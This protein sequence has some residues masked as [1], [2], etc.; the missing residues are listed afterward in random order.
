MLSSWVVDQ[1]GG[2]SEPAVRI[3]SAGMPL[4]VPFAVMVLFFSKKQLTKG[5]TAPGSN[6]IDLQK[7]VCFSSLVICLLY[8]KRLRHIL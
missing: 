6:R 7:A 1:Q 4:L 3:N 8:M 5:L 2:G